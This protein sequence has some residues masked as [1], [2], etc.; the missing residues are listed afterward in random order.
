MNEHNDNGPSM[1]DPAVVGVGAIFILLATI[2]GLFVRTSKKNWQLRGT[3][4]LLKSD[5]NKETMKKDPDLLRRADALL[6][7]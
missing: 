1:M 4:R 5:Q 7:G 6:R 2:L 3:R